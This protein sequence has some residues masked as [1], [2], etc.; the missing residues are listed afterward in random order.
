MEV[1]IQEA[2]RQFSRI[3]RRAI[4][5]EEVIITRWG[6]PVARLVRIE[7]TR[8][9]RESARGKKKSRPRERLL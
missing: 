9:R 4:E 3:L 5:G 6:V 2:K 1:G 8:R 7:A